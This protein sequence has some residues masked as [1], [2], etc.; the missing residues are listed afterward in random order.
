MALKLSS[1]QQAQLAY[2]QSLPP[3][4]QRIHAV[5]EE[6][7]ALRADES[8]VR[9]LARLLD[10]IKGNASALS[11]TGLAE[12]AG[13]MATMTRRGGG[14]QMK[15]RGLRELTGSLKINY[16]AAMRSATTPESPTSDQA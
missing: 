3:K 7:S 9:G 2:L 10:E 15:V 14:L 16:E 8:V 13:I 4:F 11:M 6:M 12:T 5:V 1:R